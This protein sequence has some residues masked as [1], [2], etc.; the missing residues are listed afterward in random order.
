[1]SNAPDYLPP[2]P[3]E[4]PRGEVCAPGLVVVDKPRGL[5][6]NALLSRIRRLA[7]QKKAGYAGTLDPMA[8][9]ILICAVGKAT[10]LLQ[11][12]SAGDKTYIARVRFGVCTDTDDAEGEVLS[13]PGA[14][15]TRDVIEAALAP[16]RGDISQVPARFSAIKVAGK[17]AYALARAGKAVNLEARQVRV[18]LLEIAADPAYAVTAEGIKVTDTDIVV[19]CSAGTYIRAL[20]R[21]LGRDLGVGAHLTALRRLQVGQYDLAAA[22]SLTELSAEVSERGKMNPIGLDEAI[23][24]MFP[25]VTL[26]SRAARALSFGQAVPR[27]TVLDTQPPE[28]LP[29]VSNAAYEGV[30][31]L[32]D[33]CAKD[34]VI[35]L[36]RLEAEVIKPVWVIRTAAAA[37]RGIS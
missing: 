5:S 22:R 3:A 11:Y 9:G 6:S 30:A 35:A 10:K 28:V 24:A 36:G 34:C 16:W 15:L 31:A 14:Q 32:V 13:A 4:V 1:M 8:T 23:L 20:A 25:Q 26:T 37:P 2:L 12:L 29:G 18:H 17:R 21:D 27:D 19:R 7:G 33:T